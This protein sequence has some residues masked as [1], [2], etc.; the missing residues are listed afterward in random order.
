MRYI[1]SAILLKEADGYR[2]DHDF[3][4]AD[5]DGTIDRFVLRFTHDQA[6]QPIV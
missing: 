3:A 2:L 5:R 1:L 6:W 4:F